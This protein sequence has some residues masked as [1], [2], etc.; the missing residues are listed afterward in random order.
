MGA[1]PAAGVGVSVTPTIS[2]VSVA[3]A[4][5]VAA[6]KIS[7]MAGKGARVVVGVK[8]GVAVGTLVVPGVITTLVFVGVAV[9]EDCC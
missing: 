8:V 7:V 2:G 9:P 5:S 1:V 4:V 6:G 3:A